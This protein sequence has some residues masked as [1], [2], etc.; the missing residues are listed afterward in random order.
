MDI[1]KNVAPLAG[2]V[3]RNIADFF[4][5]QT[6]TSRSPCGE[7]G[8]K[9]RPTPALKGVEQEQITGGLHKL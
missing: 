4:F 5:D 3:D 7:R 6:W 1:N 2:S 8:S 9:C